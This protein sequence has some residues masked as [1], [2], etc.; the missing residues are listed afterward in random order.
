[1]PPTPAHDG[2]MSDDLTEVKVQHR[3]F[4]TMAETLSDHP[5]HKGDADMGLFS[6]LGQSTDL[7]NGMADRL[8]FE[9]D[10][11]VARDPETEGNKYRRAVMRCSKCTNQSGCI[12]LQKQTSHLE[13]PPAYCMNSDMFEHANDG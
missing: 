2:L 4:C 11:Q 5:R 12:E 7:V 3:R 13:Q 8:G 1:M 10:E 6:K 9:L